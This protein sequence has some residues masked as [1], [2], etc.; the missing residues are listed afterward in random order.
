MAHTE[1]R[2][3]EPSGPIR[4]ETSDANL[5]GVERLV[6]VT[7]A[8][9][10]CVFGLIYVV[11]F[12]LKAREARLDT[13]P[14]PLAQRQGDRMPPLPRLQTTPEPDLRQFRAAE[15]AALN[16]YRWVD[17]QA[18]VVQVPVDRAIELIAEHGLPP[19][20][21][22]PAPAPAPASTGAAPAPVPAAPPVP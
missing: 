19:R 20:P 10:A 18:G 16:A 13:P 4:H 12:Q 14:P 5:G 15:D 2:R 3:G 8:F 17:M 21:S 11:Y 7:L 9:L 6:F 1:D 22:L